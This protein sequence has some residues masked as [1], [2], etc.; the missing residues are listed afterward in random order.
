MLMQKERIMTNRTIANTLLLVALMAPAA[1]AEIV[2]VKMYCFS[3]DNVPDGCIPV[4]P[5]QAYSQEQGCGWLKGQPNLFAVHLPEGN[6]DVSVT[7]ETPETAAAAT[8]KA[9]ARRL[10]LKRLKRADENLRRFT[11]NIRRPQIRT[12]ESVQLNSRERNPLSASWDD[13]LT[14]EFLPGIEGVKA[15]KIEPAPGA[16]TL[17]IA[18]DSTVTDQSNEPWAGWGQML[19]SFF[20]QGVAVANHAESGRALYSFRGEKRFDKI[21]SRIHPGD[22]LFVQFGHNDQKNNKEGAGPFTTYKADMED[23]IAKIR[24][25]GARPVLV[26]PMERR[27]W[28]GGEPGQTL[29]DYAQ[30]VRLV[31]REQGVPVIDLHAMSLKFY[32]A[33]GEEGSRRAFVHYPANTF[34]NQGPALKD[35]THHNVYGAY[36]L[37]RCIVEGIREQMP[38]LAQHLREDAGSFDPARP[39]NPD[40]IS[41]P[42]SLFIHNEKPEG[43]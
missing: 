4:M 17:Y 33:M 23:F 8:V 15:V 16:I 43:N 19:P 2:P 7:F 41:I 6:Y 40:R 27:R 30:A 35:D 36:E 9:E 37:A 13:L 24:E 12:D 39:D 34:P 28:S 31:G 1:Y 29:T 22:Y 25:K 20:K 42:A 26:S 10:M 38:E 18:G 3:K 14:L 11:V 32:A 5:K 21:L